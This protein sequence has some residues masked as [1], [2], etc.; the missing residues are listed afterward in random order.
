LIVVAGLLFA[1]GHLNSVAISMGGWRGTVVYAVY[2][3]IP[4]LE[5]FDVRDFIIHDWGTVEWLAC[6]GATVYGLLYSALLLICT[7][8]VFVRKMVTL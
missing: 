1:G 3:L 4:H 5:W 7:W 2:Y 6:L 8:M